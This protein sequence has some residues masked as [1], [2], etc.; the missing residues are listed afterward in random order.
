MY[1]NPQSTE[2]IDFTENLWG[3]PWVEG[4]IVSIHI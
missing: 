3:K 2:Y 1:E 4:Y